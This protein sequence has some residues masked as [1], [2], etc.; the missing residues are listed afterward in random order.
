VL[1]IFLAAPKD[2]NLAYDFLSNQFELEVT[3]RRS[4]SAFGKNVEAK[5]LETMGSVDA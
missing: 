5:E 2:T 4:G 1:I 3:L